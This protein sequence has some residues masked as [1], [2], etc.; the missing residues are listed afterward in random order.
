MIIAE[1]TAGMHVLFALAVLS[2]A[3]RNMITL[4]FLRARKDR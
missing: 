3:N 4:Y 2:L 1:A